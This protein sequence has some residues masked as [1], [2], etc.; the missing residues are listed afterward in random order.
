MVHILLTPSMLNCYWTGESEKFQESHSYA[1][2]VFSAREL[3]SLTLHASLNSSLKMYIT[4]NLPSRSRCC[5]GSWELSRRSVIR[6]L[7][8]LEV[9]W[10][11]VSLL[12]FAITGYCHTIFETFL[13]HCCIES[14]VITRHSHKLSRCG[15]TRSRPM[16]GCC[17]LRVA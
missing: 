16:R 4:D 3:S 9:T 13:N 12:Y 2:S 8:N 6:W 10:T 5:A 17:V 11:F 1:E 15:I 7:Y 14:L